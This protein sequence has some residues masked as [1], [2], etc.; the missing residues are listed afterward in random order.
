MVY[1][2]VFVSRCTSTIAWC[3]LLGTL[4]S[5]CI[6]KFSSSNEFIDSDDGDGDDDDEEEEDDSSISVSLIGCGEGDDAVDAVEGDLKLYLLVGIVGG[7]GEINISSSSSSS[8]RL[9]I[10][11]LFCLLLWLFF[12]F[13]ALIVLIKRFY[14][15]SLYGSPINYGKI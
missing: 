8:T 12:S 4:E 15:N 1:V 9:I 2:L 14:K 5:I 3:V 10:L 6:L 7:D 11:L 13:S